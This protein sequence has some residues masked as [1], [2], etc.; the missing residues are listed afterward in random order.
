MVMNEVTMARS[1]SPRLLHRGNY[2]YTDDEIL[3]ALGVRTKDQKER[4]AHFVQ[5]ADDQMAAEGAALS[6]PRLYPIAAR[7]PAQDPATGPAP[8][9]PSP[10]ASASASGPVSASASQA[11]AQEALRSFDKLEPELQQY[12]WAAWSV[13]VEQGAPDHALH[14]KAPLYKQTRTAGTA[15]RPASPAAAQA[16]EDADPARRAP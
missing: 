3:E 16:P 4:Q 14:T 6:N 2:G 10:S 7:T 11:A 12:H 5:H 1:L 15:S 13:A 9:G 8:A